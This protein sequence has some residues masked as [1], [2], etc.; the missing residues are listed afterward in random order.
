MS[1]THYDHC[2]MCGSKKLTMFL[3]LG[4]QP[5][6]NRNIP[7]RS[8][9]KNPEPIYPLQVWFCH[10]CA[11]VQLCDVPSK[12][13]MFSEYQFLS[14]GVG[15][16]PKHFQEYAQELKK[17]FLKKGDFV[18]EV[19]G[20]DGVL[21]VE[22]KDDMRVLNIE[23]AKN[24]APIARSR[25][26]DTLN[27]FF[28]SDVAKKVTKKYGKAKVALG[29]NSIPHIADQESVM[30][31]FKEL[32]AEG[33]VGIIQAHYL[34]DMIETL[35]YGDIYHEHMAYYAILP[36]ISFYKK[37]GLEI[38]DYQMFDFQGGSIRIYFGHKGAH[39]VSPR[40]AKLAAQEKK[41]GWNKLAI[42][43]KF[44]KDVKR[45]RDKLVKTLSALK[46]KGKHVAAYGAAAKAVP[47]LNYAGITEK[48]VDFC[49]DGLQSKQGLCMPMSHIPIISP[50][51]AKKRTVDY[52]LL[53]AWTFRG[54][55]VAKEKD[56]V[57]RG[58]KFIMPIGEI[59][60]F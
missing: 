4:K 2:R 41:K 16:T 1:L 38:F 25:G 50:E 40:V 57:A 30:M 7:P 10:D 56:F 5:P 9:L 3:D 23:P 24:I 54:H 14:T 33:G 18:V 29:N 60:I 27:D 43:K 26:V 19:G 48:M 59:E 53:L 55:I 21:L 31:G 15:N 11:L 45:S 58:G 17:K 36:L 46:K 51:E 49:V 52:Y 8:W 28:T 37:L 12:E 47:I 32:L 34:G 42:Y 20:N 35:G 39:K 22:L 6:P 44:A 13:E